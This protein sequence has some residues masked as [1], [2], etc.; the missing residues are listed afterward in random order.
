[1]SRFQSDNIGTDSY[2][3]NLSDVG[4]D[5]DD[6]GYVM[7]YNPRQSGINNRNLA[8]VRVSLSGTRISDPFIKSDKGIQS[9]LSIVDSKITGWKVAEEV[10]P[11][12]ICMEKSAYK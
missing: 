11:C 1:M 10:D 2:T 4:S 9:R 12:A 6:D 5:L 8:K 3:Y 7:V